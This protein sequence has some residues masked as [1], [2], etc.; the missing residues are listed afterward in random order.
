MAKPDVSQVLSFCKPCRHNPNNL[1]KAET[2][3][4]VK[5][6]HLAI[7]AFSR[8]PLSILEMPDMLTG[9]SLARST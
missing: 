5:S 7:V 4:D 1:I 9:S 2:G 8:L 3:L 6:Q